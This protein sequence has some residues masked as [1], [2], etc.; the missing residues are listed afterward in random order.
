MSQR[1]STF[2][3][4]V[5]KSIRYWSLGSFTTGEMSA[6]AKQ[7]C[8]CSCCSSV[9]PERADMSA[10]F[11]NSLHRTLRRL[12]CSSS[13]WRERRVSMSLS[14]SCLSDLAPAREDRSLMGQSAI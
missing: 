2:L 8:I 4:S 1:K 13:P 10:R 3:S 7:P 5:P 6:S 14:V 9:Q 11:G 12:R